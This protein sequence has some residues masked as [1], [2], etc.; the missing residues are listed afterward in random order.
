MTLLL[1][2]IIL[3]HMPFMPAKRQLTRV[4]ISEKD[5]KH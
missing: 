4:L 3:I 1:E 2:L 5:Q